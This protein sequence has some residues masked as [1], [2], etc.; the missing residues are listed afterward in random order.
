VISCRLRRRAGLGFGST[1]R[2]TPACTKYRHEMG[3]CSMSRGEPQYVPE[4]PPKSTPGLR[5]AFSE[6]S[7]AFKVITP[8]FGGG[9]KPGEN[10]PT[11][12]IRP[13]AIRGHLRFWWRATCG[14]RCENVSELRR[15]EASIWGNTEKPSAV[16]IEVRSDKAGSCK[17][18][19]KWGE[20]GK[21]DWTE[22]LSRVRYAIFPF[23]LTDEEKG[24]ARRATPPDNSCIRRC[25]WGVEFTLYL[26]YESRCESDVT[27]ALWAWANFGG[28]G[29]RTRRGCGA[30]F[31]ETL[32]P[33]VAEGDPLWPNTLC[34]RGAQ[35]PYARQW[36][37]VARV[38][39]GQPAGTALAA[40]AVGIKALAELRQGV[41][42]G[43]D[44]P[45]ARRGGQGSPAGHSRWPEAES[46]RFETGMRA[47]EPPQDATIPADRI[48][49][50]PRAQ[51]GLPIVFHFKDGPKRGKQ[52]AGHANDPY[53]TELRPLV[54]DIVGSRMASPLIIRPLALCG[55]A[56]FLPMVLCLNSDRPK[57]VALIRTGDKSEIKRYNA[58]AIQDPRLASYPNSPMNGRSSKGSALEAFMAFLAKSGFREVPL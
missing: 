5:C 51:L 47:S 58:S 27:T 29:A 21:L 26:R 15:E 14:A 7:Y 49:A 33:S 50:F 54:D 44:P 48:P 45:S 17:P 2:R 39:L 46:V 56:R 32:A 35:E 37:T 8:L 57:K 13:S 4:R 22:G 9:V 38:L 20:N 23:Q 55:G 1:S 42:V 43:R 36:P 12:L 24:V 41:N 30:L 6:R 53:E 16:D 40:W 3:G 28:V 52:A 11:L 34:C 18:V 25:Q 31:C 10:D 19:Q